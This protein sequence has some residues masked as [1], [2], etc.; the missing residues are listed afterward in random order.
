MSNNAKQA[1]RGYHAHVYYRPENKDDAALVRDQL[2]ELFDVNLGRWHDK[3][4]G[5][6]P[7]SMYQVVFS[8]EDFSDHRDNAL[9]LGEKLKLNL[10]MF[11]QT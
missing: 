8:T 9:W 4:V 1:I 2:D 3:P 7:I 11:E 6:H 10:G 5:P